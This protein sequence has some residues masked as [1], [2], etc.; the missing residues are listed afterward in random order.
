MQANKLVANKI[1]LIPTPE[2]ICAQ[3]LIERIT[4]QIK[5]VKEWGLTLF[6]KIALRYITVAVILDPTDRNRRVLAKTIGI[7]SYQTGCCWVMQCIAPP[8]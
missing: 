1:E 3:K 7:W 5:N 6:L 8:P 2:N 4:D